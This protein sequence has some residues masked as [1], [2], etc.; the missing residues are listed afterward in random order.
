[1]H[2]PEEV[3]DIQSD[4]L[5]VNGIMYSPQYAACSFYR[6]LI[7]CAMYKDGKPGQRPGRTKCEANYLSNSIHS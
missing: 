4:E 2:K 5:F 6:F 1:M 7:E 3:L